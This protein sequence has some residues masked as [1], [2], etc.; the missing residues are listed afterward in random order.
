MSLSVIATNDNITI[1][2]ANETLVI[3]RLKNEKT[4]LE[5]LE[6]VKANDVSWIESQYVNIKNAIEEK[7]NQ[8]FS[9]D[10]GRVVLKGTKVPVPEAILKK[11]MELEKDKEP[12]LPLLRFWRK[13]SENPNEE[14]RKDLYGFM[15]A[16]NIPITEDGD[17]VTEKGVIQKKGGLP[18]DLMDKHSRTIDNS[19]GNFVSMPREK[20]NPNRNETC[21]F[22]LHVGAPDY[23]R[24]WYPNDIIVE[25]IVNPKDVVSV[26]T[27]YSNTKMRVCSYRV[28]GYS[29]K[30]SRPAD[31]IVKLSDFFTEPL[32]EQK[33]AMVKDAEVT[34]GKTINYKEME[35]GTVVSKE[36]VAVEAKEGDVDLEFM[37]AKQI[38]DHVFILTGET[39]TF[40]LKSK[41]SIVKKAQEL[42]EVHKI[43]NS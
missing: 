7:S 32:P 18:G 12:I 34:E 22:G 9:V 24:Q 28:A 40:S 2:F 27:D 16:N 33:E 3:N 36:P 19:V 5:V 43:K 6:K 23:V 11:L 10:N 38:V 4:F 13:L 29:G 35:P 1:V 39:I 17:I 20:V 30:T 25:C 14:S 41:K 15:I 21:S 37:S 8:H 26:P 42:L 31:K